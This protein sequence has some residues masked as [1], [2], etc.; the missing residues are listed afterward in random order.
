MG[1][2]FKEERSELASLLE[3]R[4][5]VKVEWFDDSP[6]NDWAGHE[7][8]WLRLNDGSVVEFHAWGYDAWGVTFRGI[9][10]KEVAKRFPE[11]MET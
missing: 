4:T 3:G 10:P 6:S 2:N 9:E 11:W 1:D 5:I 7:T 8:A